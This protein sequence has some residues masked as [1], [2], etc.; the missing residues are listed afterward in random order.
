MSNKQSSYRQ[1][2]KSSSIL[3]GA[4][5]ANIVIGF[6][7]VKLV[8]V[9]LG[10]SGVGVM[11][12]LMSPIGFIASATG[13]GINYSA[14]RDISEA[15]GTKDEK[16]IAKT[17]GVVRMW[18][19]FTG[20]LGMV[21]T[22]TLAPWLSKLTFGNF[23]YTISFIII[24]ISL[25]LNAINGGQKALLQGLR[26]LKALAKTN[27]IGSALGLMTSLPLYYFYGL[28]GIP[29]A[30]VIASATNLLIS[31]FYSKEVKLP[32]VPKSN[33]LDIIRQGS[34][35]V[36]LG[37][38]L[39]I[40]GM[41]GMGVRYLINIYISNEGGID[42]VGLYQAGFSLINTYIGLIFTAMGSD[43][44]PRLAAVNKDN[45][46]CFETINYQINISVTIL[47][48]LCALLIT[49]LPIII[50][51]LYSKNFLDVVPMGQWLA[52]SIF[53]KSI[54]WA[55]GYLY[56]AKGALKTAFIIDN[57]LNLIL[58]FGYTLFYKFFGL[59]GLG[60]AD[61]LF[62]SIA[63][64]LS[65]FISHYKYG[66]LFSKETILQLLKYGSILLFVFLLTRFLPQQQIYI[67]G[68]FIS[69]LIMTLSIIDLNKNLDLVKYIKGRLKL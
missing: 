1:I 26:R 53:I 6:V 3:G 8:A 45:A 51:L 61:L 62:Y 68:S 18:V 49:F 63:L 32:K 39:T 36:K 48:P 14:V 59:V 55:L 40:S 37:I 20:I 7:R 15:A 10:T 23:E 30:I 21:I 57:V 11:G 28:K 13:L 43:Y 60:M 58:L 22:L 64:P 47:T 42:Q 69:L 33:L 19:L 2:L 46:K 65:F 17:L 38:V 44:Y 67:Y 29:M 54:V 34:M 66:F 35:M 52:L 41:I 4:Q 27:I 9:L 5:V 56:L 25:L 24:S 50:K 16:R 12:L 31:W